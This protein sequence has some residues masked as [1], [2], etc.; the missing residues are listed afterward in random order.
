MSFIITFASTH[1]VHDHDAFRLQVGAGDFEVFDDFLARL[2]NPEG[3]ILSRED[4]DLGPVP[5]SHIL[6]QQPDSF[7]LTFRQL[8]QVVVSTPLESVAANVDAEGGP[9]GTRFNPFATDRKRTAEVLTQCLWLASKGFLVGLF[10]E[11]D[12]V[13]R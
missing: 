13:I 8:V 12:F 6:L 7:L 3:K 4:V 5:F 2:E 1:H 11:F 9:F 10:E